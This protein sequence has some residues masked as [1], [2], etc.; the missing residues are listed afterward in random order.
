MAQGGDP[1]SRDDDTSD[2]GKGGPGYTI[3]CECYQDNARMHFRG[4]LSMAHAGKDSG[5]SQFFITHLPTYWLNA[6]KDAETGHT[7]FGR[8]VK[9]LDIAA[10]L[11]IGDKIE[12]TKV[13]FKRDHEYKP[14][15]TA[16]EKPDP[17][18]MIRRGRK[19]R[20]TAYRKNASEYGKKSF[21]AKY[22]CSGTSSSANPSSP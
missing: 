18:S 2:D 19:R 1:N 14:V 21:R 12:S 17:T 20:M 9:G 7:V 11:E 3:K 6:N 15:M 8:V 16:E 4:S 13:L 5:G 10:A 22:L